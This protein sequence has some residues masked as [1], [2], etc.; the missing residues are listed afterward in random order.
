MTNLQPKK[1][2]KRLL[3][4]RLLWTGVLLLLQVCFVLLLAGGLSGL[5]PGWDLALRG[6]SIGAV[7]WLLSR[8][9]HP[10]YKIR[11]V[12]LMVLLPR[13]GGLFYLCFGNKRLSHQRKKLLE[14]YRSAAIP[15]PQ[16]QE[17]LCRLEQQSPGQARLAR[18]L[19]QAAGAP[20]WDNTA[21]RY[22]PSGELLFQD[23]LQQLEKA[24]RFVFLEF[25]IVAQGELWDS[26]LE[27][28]RRKAAQGVEVRLLYDDAGSINTL[29][30]GYEQ[31]LRAWG[32]RAAIFN[33]LRPRLNPYLN[34]RD[35]RKICVIDGDMGYTGG[36]NLSDEYVNRRQRCGHWKDGGV[37]LRGAAVGSLS[38]LF[39]QQWQYVTGELRDPTPYLPQRE[40]EADGFV[41]VFGS[42]PISGRAVAKGAYLQLCNQASRSLSL[43]SPYLIP[44]DETL[45]TLISAAASGV[46]VRLVLP[47][48]PDKS[49]VHAVTRSFYAPLL[50]QGIRIFEYTPGFIHSKVLLA[51]ERCAM[52]GTANLDYRSFYSNFECAAVLYGCSA[53][54]E[55][56]QDVQATLALCQEVSLAQSQATPWPNKL[57]RLLLRSL[58]PLM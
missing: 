10:S 6:L 8:P 7:I 9:V 53:V 36:V 48:V 25:F 58:A 13:S 57:L 17:L 34:C 19:Q 26:V 3:S 29:P 24:Q 12:I 1:Q 56:R 52:I 11:W 15:A 27:I 30:E 37:R 55:L 23:L 47:H 4:L 38:R 40:A 20:L 18:Y 54:E 41:Q 43:F 49:Y 42:E 2:W 33:P 32:I 31:Q 46:E 51:D 44:D 21:A 50:R 39:L 5:H 35:H 16:T 45:S 28:L 14:Q 22:F